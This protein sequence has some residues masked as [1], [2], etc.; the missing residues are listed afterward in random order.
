MIS[1]IGKIS[2]F[3]LVSI[4]LRLLRLEEKYYIMQI[5]MNNLRSIEITFFLIYHMHV[6]FDWQDEAYEYRTEKK[7]HIINNHNF[8]FFLSIFKIFH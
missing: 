7:D 2:S 6:C 5:E 4:E 3:H 1:S 8:H